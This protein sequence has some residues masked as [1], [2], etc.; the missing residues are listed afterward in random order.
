TI[1]EGQPVELLRGLVDGIGARPFLS[2]KSPDGVRLTEK[3]LT[4]EKSHNHKSALAEILEFLERH[5]AEATIEAVGHRVVHGGV[6]YHAPVLVDEQ[7]LDALKNLR[8]LAPLH[9]PH[10]IEGIEAARA[11]FP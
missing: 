1:R 6:D 7:V 11:V 9:Q 3:P 2:V 8:P 5:N 4:S 10:N